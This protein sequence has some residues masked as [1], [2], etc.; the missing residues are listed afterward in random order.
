MP[1][2]LQKNIKVDY[3]YAGHMMYLHDEDRVNLHNNIAAFIDH[4]TQQ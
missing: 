1:E 2:A 4:A 3:Y